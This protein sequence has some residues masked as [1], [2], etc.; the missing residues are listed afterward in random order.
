MFKHLKNKNN[1]SKLGSCKLFKNF[2]CIKIIHNKNNNLFFKSINFPN[3]NHNSMINLTTSYKSKK[4]SLIFLYK[5]INC[6]VKRSFCKKQ[7][8]ISKTNKKKLFLNTNKNS[9]SNQLQSKINKNKKISTNYKHKKK[10][11]KWKFWA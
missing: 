7:F 10:K 5:L 11:W 4:I 3:F 2:K 8:K 1:K 6:K 9:K